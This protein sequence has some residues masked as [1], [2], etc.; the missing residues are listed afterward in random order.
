M[1][2]EKREIGVRD[3]GEER[4][5]SKRNERDRERTS[6]PTLNQI[7]FPLTTLDLQFSIKIKY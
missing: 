5:I 3:E 1:R 2:G 7:V 6:T 4:E